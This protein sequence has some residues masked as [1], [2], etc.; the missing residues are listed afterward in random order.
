[1]SLP[2]SNSEFLLLWMTL[3]CVMCTPFFDYSELFVHFSSKKE[4]KVLLEEFIG[5]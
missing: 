4:E 5:N 2:P 3:E 1:M